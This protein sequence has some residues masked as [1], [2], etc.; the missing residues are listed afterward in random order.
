MPWLEG[1]FM[2][3]LPRQEDLKIGRLFLSMHFKPA[4]NIHTLG[5]QRF[6]VVLEVENHPL[7][8]S[9]Y[10]YF[11]VNPIKLPDPTDSCLCYLKPILFQIGS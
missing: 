10:L 9:S 5:F 8:N 2:L 7:T 3:V 11:P 4:Y 1:L 6:F